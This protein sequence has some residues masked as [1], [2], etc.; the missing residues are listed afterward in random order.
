MSAHTPGPWRVYEKTGNGQFEVVGP[1]PENVEIV[2][3]HSGEV[4]DSEN[5]ANA[6]I[7]AAAPDGVLFAQ[8]FLEWYSNQSIDGN[9]AQIVGLATRAGE[10]R[11]FLKKAGVL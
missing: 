11:A 1:E 3:C 6:K 7:I 10:A 8:T 5:K 2:G 4:P 9:R